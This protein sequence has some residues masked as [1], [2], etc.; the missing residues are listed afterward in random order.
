MWNIPSKFLEKREDICIG[1]KDSRIGTKVIDSGR[2]TNGI[3]SL[4]VAFV[5]VYISSN[6]YVLLL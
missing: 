1:K 4:L 3:Y 6:K 2:I 5:N